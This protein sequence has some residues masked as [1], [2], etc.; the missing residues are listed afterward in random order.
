VCISWTIKCLI[1]LM[2]GATMKFLLPI[3]FVHT[4][5]HTHTHTHSMGLKFTKMIVICAISHKHTK[6]AKCKE[7]FQFKIVYS[8]T[9]HSYAVKIHQQLK[10]LQNYNWKVT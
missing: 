3:H 1:L 7:L 5:T 9:D 10:G 4:H 6:Y 8:I 2:H